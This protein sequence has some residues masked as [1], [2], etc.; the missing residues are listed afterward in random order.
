MRKYVIKSDPSELDGN[1]SCAF[2]LYKTFASPLRIDLLKPL[3][4]V[5]LQT[6]SGV[7]SRQIL[8]GFHL[9]DYAQGG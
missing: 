9:L 8:K 6:L 4:L 1:F 3:V 5:P 7:W 2:E